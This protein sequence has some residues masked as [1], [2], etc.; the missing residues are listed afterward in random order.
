MEKVPNADQSGQSIVDRAE[1]AIRSWAGVSSIE[2]AA[3]LLDTW[4]YARDMTDEERGEVLAR[5]SEGQDVP[6]SA[7]DEDGRTVVTTVPEHEI[8]IQQMP[9]GPI[10]V[11][12]SCGRWGGVA[13]SVKVAERDG[14]RHVEKQTAT[15][16]ERRAWW[17]GYA[18]AWRDATSHSTT[19]A[20]AH[21]AGYLEAAGGYLETVRAMLPEQYRPAAMAEEAATVV[22]TATV[23]I[24]HMQVA[25]WGGVP[26][27]CGVE[28][29][30]GVTYDNFDTIAEA[31][32][33][34]DQHIEAARAA[35]EEGGQ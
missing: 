26:G 1:A 7:A 20:D 2:I 29:A 4:K 17:R 16:G 13:P 9:G 10:E 3:A 18:A 35:V 30:C 14:A 19:A 33:L 21:A 25:G 22:E 24:E 23:G 8:R 34:L 27:E 31:S 5:F 32:E 6:R 12:C 15:E 28:C 11:R